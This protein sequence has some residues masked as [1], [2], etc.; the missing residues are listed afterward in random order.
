MAL[1]FIFNRETGEPIFE[2]EEFMPVVLPYR[3]R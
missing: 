2:S 1:L 3:S